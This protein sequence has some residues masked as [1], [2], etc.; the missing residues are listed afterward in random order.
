MTAPMNAAGSERDPLRPAAIV[1]R[2]SSPGRG[3]RVLRYHR[4]NAQAAAEMWSAPWELLHCQ[5]C[6]EHTLHRA[7]YW[8]S[9]PCV[10]EPPIQAIDGTEIGRVN[11]R[12]QVLWCEGHR[13]PAPNRIT[14]PILSPEGFVEQGTLGD[15][16]GRGED[17]V[18]EE[19]RDE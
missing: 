7:V 18:D 14:D 9:L 10:F 17:D 19:T 16:A 3:R 11:M 15:P 2:D 6:A 5:L 8:Y 1:D 13:G 4:S 12:V